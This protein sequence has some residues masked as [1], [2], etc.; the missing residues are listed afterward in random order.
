[1]YGE[2]LAKRTA[3]RGAAGVARVPLRGAAAGAAVMVTSVP[4]LMVALLYDGASP[5]SPPP[6]SSPARTPARPRSSSEHR[7][8]GTSVFRRVPAHNFN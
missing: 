8:G 4:I 5:T 1:M 3:R 7:H 2:R 6:S